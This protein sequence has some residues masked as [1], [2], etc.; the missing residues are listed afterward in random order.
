MQ[1][2]NFKNHMQFVKGYHFVLSPLLLTGII[3]SIVNLCFHLHDGL[4][5]TSL[6]ISALFLCSLLIS[7]YSRVFALKA[8]DRA[9]R[10]EESLRHFVLTGKLPDNRLSNGQIIALRFAP[11]QEFLLLS[12]RAVSENLSPKEIK[13]AIKDWKGDYNRV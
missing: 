5:I 11:D 3:T 6:F 2:Q 7:Y 12:G 9:I 10:A 4:L 8:Q 1:P 13:M